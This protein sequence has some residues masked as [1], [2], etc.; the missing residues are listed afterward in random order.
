MRETYTILSLN[1]ARCVDV[2][3]VRIEELTGLH[4]SSIG[5]RMGQRIFALLTASGGAEL[6]IEGTHE[7]GTAEI[8]VIP[9]LVVRGVDSTITVEL[10]TIVARYTG[11]RVIR[12]SVGAG[13]D[14]LKLIHEPTR[15]HCVP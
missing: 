13:N 10:S 14:D 1:I 2:K 12:I 7:H 3:N 6:C 5:W 8:R 15:V 11:H 9:V 4:W